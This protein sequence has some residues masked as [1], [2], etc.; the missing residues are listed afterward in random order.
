MMNNENERYNKTTRAGGARQ[1]GKFN[2]VDAF[3]VILIIAVV[4][5]LIAYFLPGISSYF[6]DGD[7]Y[8]VTYEI[9][10]RGIDSDVDLK[11][12][13]S[14]MPVFD[15]R[16][17]SEIGQVKTEVVVNPHGVLVNSGELIENGNGEYKGNI[18][19]HPTLKDIVITVE[20]EA[21]YSGENA[22]F[23]I[24]GQRIAV[25]REFNVRFGGFTGVGY[26]TGL[27]FK[28]AS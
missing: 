13:T 9:E 6:S 14:G 5:M 3:L 12:I 20:G 1:R 7:K 16:N 28:S 22:S 24:N 26:C 18:V 27:H 11:G 25:G 8:I 19:S 21:I 17:N 10:F 4:A 15:A 23:L 2:F